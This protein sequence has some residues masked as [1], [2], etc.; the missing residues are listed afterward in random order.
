MHDTILDPTQATHSPAAFASQLADERAAD[1][2]EVLNEQTP[3]IIASVL[4]HLPPERAIEVLDLPGL[5][6]RPE[7]VSALP[8]DTAL[9]LLAGVSA[10]SAADIFRQLDEPHRSELL[11]RLDP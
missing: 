9:T 7:I 4:Q 8:R 2:V 11:D 1:I 10:D 5:D 6:H 3:E